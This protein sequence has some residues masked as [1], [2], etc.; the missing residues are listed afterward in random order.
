MAQS[1][2]LYNSKK[3]ESYASLGDNAPM[4]L[5]LTASSK[6]NGEPNDESIGQNRYSLRGDI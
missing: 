3:E 4:V 1:K 5:D 2:K 6:A